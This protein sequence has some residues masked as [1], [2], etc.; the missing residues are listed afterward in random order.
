MAAETRTNN[1]SITTGQ[2]RDFR[3]YARILLKYAPLIIL[4]TVITTAAAIVYT[5]MARPVYEARVMLRIEKQNVNMPGLN[6]LYFTDNRDFDYFQT[7]IKLFKSRSLIKETLKALQD[8]HMAYK[9]EGVTSEEGLVSSFLSK[10]KIKPELRSQL[11]YLIIEDE[12]KFKAQAFANTLAQKYIDE[13][14]RRRGQAAES[15]GKWIEK[16]TNEQELEILKKEQELNTFKYSNNVAQVSTM[17]ADLQKEIMQHGAE[18]AQLNGR[19]SG[20]NLEET[21]LFT[22]NEQIRKLETDIDRKQ[23][24]I[25]E[26]EAISTEAQMLELKVKTLRNEYQNLLRIYTQTIM[27][28]DFKPQNISI[29]DKA[30]VPH[31]PAR[32]RPTI[33]VMFG[34]IFGLIIGVCV[35]FVLE[36]LDDTIKSPTDV[37]TFLKVPFIGLIPSMDRKREKVP[38]EGIVEHQPKGAIAENYRAIRTNILFSSGKPVRQM[39][40]T[41]AGPSEGK[42]TTCVNIAQ[43][44]AKAGDRTLIID[45]DMRRPRLRKIFELEPNTT[46]LSN[47]LVGNATI[48]EIIHPT[49]TDGLFIIPSGPIPPNPVELLNHPRLK[50]LMAYAAE[51]F[52]RVLYDTPPVIAV[53]DSAILARLADGV[54]FSVHGGQSH[55]DVIKRGID[56]LSKVGSHIFGVVLNN[57]NIYRASYYDYYYYNYYRYAYEYSYRKSGGKKTRK[58]RT[59]TKSSEAV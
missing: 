2:A 44:M 39:V 6:S 19:K 35:S 36:Y 46:G 16:R 40:V 50:E 1:D 49:K 31:V 32:P 38:I 29:V 45:A 47:F 37:D 7:Q 48:E 53:T 8:I 10:I 22:I 28:K 27:T 57:V 24:R 34:I 21:E 11:V 9:A 59:E 12:N 26:L 25:K 17:L 54:I 58:K 56:T 15:F 33:N 18:I 51:H 20:G 41:S 52:D 3:A 30:E 23:K 5:L 14:I 42:T 55:R 13:T 43:V 4:I